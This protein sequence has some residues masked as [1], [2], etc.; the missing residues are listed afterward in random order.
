MQDL[1]SCESSTAASSK[2]GAVSCGSAVKLLCCTTYRHYLLLT[3]A[4]VDGW[5]AAS[6]QQRLIAM[7]D[8]T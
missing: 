1:A 7:T 6:D 2:P 3:R 5:E 4:C 8:N